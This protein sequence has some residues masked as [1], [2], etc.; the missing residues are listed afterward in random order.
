LGRTSEPL[1]AIG[2]SQAKKLAERTSGL[3]I[4]IILFTYININSRI[5]SQG[6]QQIFKLT[7]I[8]AGFLILI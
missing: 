3:G 5:Y 1:N 6:N 8:R 7:N 4:K 2:L